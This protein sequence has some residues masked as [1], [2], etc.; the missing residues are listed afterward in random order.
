M[1]RIETLKKL[2]KYLG[3]KT[4]VGFQTRNPV[5][6]AHEYIEKTDTGIVDGLFFNPLVGETKSDDIPADVRSRKL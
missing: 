3:W 5:H 4:V 6:R 1:T 2:C